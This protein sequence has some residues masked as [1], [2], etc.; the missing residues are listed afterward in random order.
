M[1]TPSTDL[2]HLPTDD[3]PALPT[4]RQSAASP[5]LR[6]LACY[7]GMVV[8]I[9]AAVSAYLAGSAR[10]NFWDRDE[11]WY[12]QTSK[13][14][15]ET[16]NW[17]VPEFLGKL[18]TAKPIFI[19][20]CQAISMSLFGTN[21]FAAR[22]V[23]A[24]AMA[25]TLLLLSI[26]LSRAIGA[27]RTLLTLLIFASSAMVMAAAKMCLTDSVQLVF[28]T[29]AQLCLYR[30]YRSSGI[31]RPL[32]WETDRVRNTPGTYTAASNRRVALLMWFFIAMGVLTKGPFILAI[33]LSTLVMLTLFDVGKRFRSLQAWRR[34]LGWWREFRVLAGLGIVAVALMFWLIPLQMREPTFFTR[35]LYEPYKHLTSNQDGNMPLPGYYLIAIWPTF[36]PWCLVLP[37]ALV[38][39]WK[40]R[41]APPIRFALATILGNWL[42]AESMVTKLPH[43][44]LPSYSSL[45]FLAATALIRCGRRQH[46][47]LAQKA[48]YLML[49]LWTCGGLALACVPWLAALKFNDFSRLGAAVFTAAGVVY[50][51]LCVIL[52][53]RQRFGIAAVIMGGGMLGLIA[54]LYTLY[55]PQ[56]MFLRVPSQVGYTLRQLGAVQEGQVIMTGYA[57]PSLGFYQGGTIR[58]L[59]KKDFRAMP[60]D[61]WPTWVVTTAKLFDSLPEDWK[62]RAE[63]KARFHGL[64]YN[65]G[66]S[67]VDVLVLQKKVVASPATLPV[68]IPTTLPTTAPATLPTTLPAAET[69]A[70]Q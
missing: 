3:V 29:G 2:N 17:I 39:G 57:E 54:I 47:D 45:A 35:L 27:R 56:A 23:S 64:N 41:N 7:L 36:F 16:G 60:P 59:D 49:G 10:V 40:H 12:A 6:R 26:T 19:Y 4:P 69:P 1:T 31:R 66:D 30:L 11:A 37:T 52:M 13:R 63:I 25:L 33:L 34:T 18:R 58:D 24:V 65:T 28:I 50:L 5:R 22:L 48:F 38:L 21:E 43:Y 61:Q 55:L 14:M 44:M 70:A 46:P 67:I 20:W 68:A 53:A 51:T 62:S 9:A 42:F 8:V 32:S 15:V